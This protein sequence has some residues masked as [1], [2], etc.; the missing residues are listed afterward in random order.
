[1]C[2]GTTR[3]VLGEFSELQYSLSPSFQAARLLVIY[4]NNVSQNFHF[5]L[6]KMAIKS[7]ILTLFI[8]TTIINFAVFNQRAVTQI[9]GLS[10]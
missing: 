1:M 4:R 7:S 8:N 2:T 5:R 6:P 10:F 9:F 3:T